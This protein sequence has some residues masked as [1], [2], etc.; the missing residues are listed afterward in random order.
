[1]KCAHC[2]KEF[3]TYNG[4]CPFCHSKNEKD[5]VEKSWIKY[6][7]IVSHHTPISDKSRYPSGYTRFQ[8]SA[9]TGKSSN[10]TLK[11]A[12]MGGIALLVVLSIVA[13][14]Q[15]LIGGLSSIGS[16]P[17]I[18]VTPEETIPS[19]HTVTITSTTAQPILTYSGSNAGT[20]SPYGGNSDPIASKPV[21]PDYT[22][23]GYRRGENPHVEPGTMVLVTPYPIVSAPATTVSTPAT[24]VSTPAPANTVSTP[25]QPLNQDSIPIG[26]RNAAAKALSYLRSSS[27]SRDGLIKQLEYEGF[28]HQDAVYGVDQSGANWNEQ[29]ALKAKSYLRSSS[30][31]RSGLVDQ[32][33]YEGFTPQQAE[34]GVAQSGADWNE[35]AAL[36]AKSYLR[37]SS[38][39]RSGLIDQLEYE[40]FTPQQAEYGVAQ[41][42]ADWNEQ[43]ALKAASYL[44]YSSF[45]RSGLI[46][47]LEYEGFTPQQAEYGVRAVGY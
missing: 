39:S 26:E 1:M 32:L 42:G 35:Q 28:T 17:E 9:G 13:M 45:S 20:L 31:S 7:P 2:G 47:Q 33:E 5:T 12:L 29:A 30:F 14:A 16:A 10:K 19:L 3:E 4:I 40:G 34:Y 38:F 36:K 22:A 6:A 11:Y 41:S 24:T 15:I 37:S 8:N 18:S 21:A 23:P 25:A 44:K 27:F 43:A 46:D